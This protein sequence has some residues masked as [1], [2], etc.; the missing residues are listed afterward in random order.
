[1]TDD[2]V[3]ADYTAAERLGRAVRRW[4][5]AM[6][7]NPSANYDAEVAYR[8]ELVSLYAR[9][10]VRAVDALPAEQQ[11][12]GWQ[13]PMRYWYYVAWEAVDSHGCRV[14]GWGD[15]CTPGPATQY[16]HITAMLEA[17]RAAQ[18]ERLAGLDMHAT[19]YTLLRVEPAPADGSADQGAS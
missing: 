14:C 17:L 15:A 10:L 7:A 18:P 2:E 12:V 19:F 9:D 6:D 8:Q 13:Q 16:Q 11:P 1:M 3:S 5:K 4:H